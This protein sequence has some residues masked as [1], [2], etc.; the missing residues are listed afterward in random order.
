M[1]RLTDQEL[2]E[3]GVDTIGARM[4]FCDAVRVQEAGVGYESQEHGNKED[5][6]G[7]AKEE[8]SEGTATGDQ[9]Q[10]KETGE[11]VGAEAT[12][13]GLDEQEEERGSEEPFFMLKRSPLEKKSH[14]Y[15]INSARYNRKNVFK[16]GIHQGLFKSDVSVFRAFFL[17][18]FG[19]HFRQGTSM[20]IQVYSKLIPNKA[21]ILG[22]LRGNFKLLCFDFQNLKS[23]GGN[24]CVSIFC[25]NNTIDESF[26]EISAHDVFI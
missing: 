2:K 19:I 22:H 4:R 20:S 12:H 9:N 11:A 25:I 17:D 23:R 15:L 21:Q 3:L 7:V 10:E 18:I 6:G 8:E 26:G 16:S 14:K 5:T 13:T 1:S 24:I